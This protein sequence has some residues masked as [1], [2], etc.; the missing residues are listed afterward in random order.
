[1][2]DK[3]MELPGPLMAAGLQSDDH[4]TIQLSI[5]IKI[6]RRIIMSMIAEI[7]M[8]SIVG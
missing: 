5:F 7:S 1:M 6:K 2:L 3:S 8:G 4:A